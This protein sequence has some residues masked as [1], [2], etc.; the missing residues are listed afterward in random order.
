MSYKWIFCGGMPRS[1]STLQYQIV[2]ELVEYDSKGARLGWQP[3][4]KINDFIIQK[5]D[6]NKCFQGFNV[7]KTHVCTDV[8]KGR[9]IRNQAEIFY[10][11]RDVRD[12]IVS[13]SRKFGKTIDELLDCNFLQSIIDQHKEWTSLPN[14]ITSSYNDLRYNLYN[15]LTR[16]AEILKLEV[17]LSARNHIFNQLSFDNQKRNLGASSLSSNSN[18]SSYKS[19]KY[20]SRT[21]LHINHI[22]DG[23]S[24]YWINELTNEQAQSIERVAK[25]WLANNNFL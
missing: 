8:L 18:L 16:Y 4:D 19:D 5:E 12:V 3:P 15:E 11:Y 24:G 9:A 14:I 2:S 7:L 1:G 13:Q 21:L 6:D 20:D 22:T 25:K 10:C 23:G 17:S